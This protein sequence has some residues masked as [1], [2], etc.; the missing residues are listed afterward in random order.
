MPFSG[1]YNPETIFISVDFPAPFSPNKACT[2]PQ[3]EEKKASI[4]AGFPSKL[5]QM[6]SNSRA[7]LLIKIKTKYFYQTKY[8]LISRTYYTFNKVIHTP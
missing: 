8:R 3:P 2:S 6:P 5:L 1:L 4:R 7:E